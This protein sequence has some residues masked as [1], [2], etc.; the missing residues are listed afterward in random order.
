MKKLLLILALLIII[1]CKNVSVEDQF[2]QTLPKLLVLSPQNNKIFDPGTTQI[3]VELS[4]SELSLTEEGNSS[5]K[6]IIKLILDNNEIAKINTTNYLLKNIEHG[7]H[8]LIIDI[9]RLNGN[10]Y[11]VKQEINFTIPREIPVIKFLEPKTGFI[12]NQSKV[13]VKLTADKF[14]FE[15]GD[16]AV[17]MISEA[18]HE[19]KQNTYDL[20]LT[21]AKYKLEASLFDKN[22]KDLNAKKTTEFTVKGIPPK[23]PKGIP[24]FQIW[25]P[26]ENSNI[27]GDFMSLSLIMENFFIEDKTN[28]S[29]R[30]NYGHFLVWL[31]NATEPIKMYSG[32]K[33]IH[34]LLAGKNTIRVEM[35]HNDDSTYYVER[36]TTFNG[37]TTTSKKV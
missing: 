15:K 6:G 26:Q 10:T 31:N 3:N 14:S 11:N 32:T 5:N 22:G 34:N 8:N 7:E 1:S 35:I 27:K 36:T 21:P 37:Q 24:N 18:R 16:Y 23:G 9:V 13:Q 17:L 25:W 12:T 30:L 29:N 4:V 2:Q 28:V 33:T 20:N 19:M